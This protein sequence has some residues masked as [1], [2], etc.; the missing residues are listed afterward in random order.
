MKS[1]AETTVE[2]GLSLGSNLGDRLR[3]L[4]AARDRVCA[5]P[6]AALLAQSRVYETEPVDV[7][8]AY[9]DLAFLNAV[10]VV[11]SGMPPRVLHARLHA[12]EAELGRER[13]GDRNAPRAIDIDLLYAGDLRV[14]DA[15][16]TVPH[17]RWAERRFVVQPLADVR[18]NRVLPGEP[19][20]VREVL[21]AL[22]REP[23]VV[24]FAEEW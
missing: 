20:T 23:A 24:P 4:R 9:R 8:A 14:R 13:S 6:G 15:V 10:L 19:R 18:P 21:F 12:I 3:N 5:L 1:R 16:L 2:Y 22:P 17:A 11:E 7:S